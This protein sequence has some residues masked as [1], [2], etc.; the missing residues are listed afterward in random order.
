MREL[1]GSTI[2]RVRRPRPE[3]RKRELTGDTRIRLSQIKDLR[4]W[5]EDYRHANPGDVRR[6][7]DGKLHIKRNH[8]WQVVTNPEE[9]LPKEMTPP[10]KI[11][12]FPKEVTTEKEY[13]E[14][15]DNLFKRNYKDM[16]NYIH[17]PD[18]NKKLAF[19]LG[20]TDKTQFIYKED[21]KH[22]NPARKGDEEQS[23]SKGEYLLIPKVLKQAKKAYF[24]PVRKN[25]IITFKDANNPKK[26][27]KIVMEKTPK[28]S[29]IVTASKVNKK[30]DIVLK[31]SR[32]I[33]R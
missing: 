16:P 7:A 3:P 13:K 11:K 28:G 9:Y 10:G 26:V 18:I 23:L 12:K 30:D 21:Y 32:P 1:T 25:Y 29:Y 22:I 8:G 20:I 27:N 19:Q 31:K 17:F 33:K 4:E 2:I 5:V 15:V 24:D 14:F 6:W